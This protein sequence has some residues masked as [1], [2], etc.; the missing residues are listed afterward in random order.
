MAGRP[1]APLLLYLVSPAAAN[2]SG[3]IFGAYGFK[4]IRWSEPHHERSLDSSGSWDLN[5]LFERFPAT[6]GES[7]SLESDLLWPMTSVD[8][9]QAD[10]FSQGPDLGDGR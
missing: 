1:V 3:R 6:L 9:G 2:I 4:Y 8:Q 7:L 5:E 10:A